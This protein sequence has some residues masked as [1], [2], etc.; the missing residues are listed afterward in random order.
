MGE[1]EKMC[2][3]SY[4]RSIEQEERFWSMWKRC[5]VAEGGVWVSEGIGRSL[6]GW[7][8]TTRSEDTDFSRQRF[9]FCVAR[10]GEVLG[11]GVAWFLGVLWVVLG[12]DGAKVFGQEVEMVCGEMLRD[13]G[14]RWG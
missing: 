5:F 9:G 7:W 12:W 2:G 11:A 8:A 3:T 6:V 13:G 10:G 1:L 14:M 4:A